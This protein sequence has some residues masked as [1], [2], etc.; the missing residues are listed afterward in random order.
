MTPR[1]GGIG[2]DD[3]PQ[4]VLITGGTGSFGSNLTRFLLSLDRPPRI[5]IYSRDEHKQEDLARE[6][7]DDRVTF[8][9]GDIRDGRR[10]RRALD[11]CDALVH[12][13]ALKVVAQGEQHVSECIGVNVT[14]TERVVEAAIEAGVERSILI[15]SD[16]AVQP[17]NTYGLSK[18]LAERLFIHANRQA[19]SRGLHF[20]AARGG[21]VWG[22]RGSVVEVWKAQ[23]AAGQPITVYDPDTLRFHLLMQDWT[24]F[25]WR[26]LMEQHGGEV[27]VPKLRAWRLGDVASALGGPRVDQAGRN[28]DKR[29]EVLIGY[30]EEVH[31][32]DAGWAYVVEPPAELRAVWAYAPYH[33][34]PTPGRWADFCEYS[35]DRVE[36]LSVDELRTIL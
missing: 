28:G 19:V 11:G 23:Q 6:L 5:R 1:G 14:G 9:L 30:S 27:F 29:S 13:A 8:I 18:A 22:S 10:L 35:S 4:C 2:R 34:P 33:S 17:I 32:V 12:A 25:V 31:A 15:S 7:H 26:S 36:R 20:A 3:A 24:A 16:K 21:N